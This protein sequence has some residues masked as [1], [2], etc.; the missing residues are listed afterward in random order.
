MT[1]I[2]IVNQMIEEGY[3]LIDETPEQ[4]ARRFTEED[5]YMFL[6]FFRRYNEEKAHSWRKTYVCE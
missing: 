4:F 1:K 6:T 3:S 2:E 5:L